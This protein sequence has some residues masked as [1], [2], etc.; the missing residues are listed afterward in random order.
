MQLS[1]GAPDGGPITADTDDAG[2]YEFK[3]LKPGTY[4]ISI[5]QPGFTPFT[6]TVT[7]ES[8]TGSAW[9]FALELQTV[10]E[11]VEVS[12]DHSVHSDRETR[13]PPSVTLTQRQLISL[14][15][16]QEKI[17]EVLPVTPGVVKTR[18]EN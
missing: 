3:D 6:K 9:I 14:P 10:T 4:T 17:R 18:T 2:H 11:Q 13:R 7:A 8:G 12:E 16:A 1:H 5:N 15:T